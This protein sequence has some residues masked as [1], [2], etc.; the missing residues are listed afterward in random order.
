MHKLNN[1]SKILLTITLIFGSIWLGG[2]IARHLVI[3][4]FFDPDNFKL[5]DIY[6]NST[7]QNSIRL[8]QSLLVLNI[9]TY[10]IF[11]IFLFLFII[12]SRI[13]LKQNGWLF[14]CLLIV[15]ITAPFEI[16]LLTKDYEI[17]LQIVNVKFDSLNVLT[18]I[19]NRIEVLSSF[20]II[21]IF[22]YISMFFLIIFKPLTKL[23]EN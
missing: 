16:F 3:Y 11:L 1:I 8:I 19:K 10:S 21:E 13:N 4:Q 5:L 14:I 2:Y 23:N 17:L 9:I 22:A 20:S 7:S 12:V 18:L 6:N 15:L